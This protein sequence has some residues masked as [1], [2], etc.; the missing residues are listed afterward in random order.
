M[1][2]STIHLMTQLRDGLG[3]IVLPEVTSGTARA[4]VDL[5]TRVLNNLLAGQTVRSSLEAEHR[6]A[7]A[8]ALD[9]ALRQL[10][11]MAALSVSPVPAVAS[12]VPFSPLET[13]LSR[14]MAAC[15]PEAPPDIR[16]AALACLRSVVEAERRFRE[17][18]DPEVA[19]GRESLFAGGRLKREPAPERVIEDRQPTPAR[20]EA[21][22]RRQS[23]EWSGAV[24]ERLGLLSG[25]FGKETI[26]VTVRRG[27]VS[28]DLVIRRDLP[29]SQ[30]DATVT[31][32]FAPLQA[33]FAAGMRVPE[34]L[35]LETDPEVFGTPF[36]LMRKVEGTS[37]ISGWRDDPHKVDACLRSWARQ[38][39]LLHRLELP[40]E[41]VAGRETRTTRDW[42][43]AQIGRFHAMFAARRVAPSPLLTAGYAWLRANVPDSGVSPR[44]VH[45][46]L[47]FHNMLTLDGE[48][49]AI[50]DWEYAHPGDPQEDLNYVR[51]CVE[52]IGSWERFLSYYEGFGGP[53]WRPQ[54]ARFWEVWRGVWI[55]TGCVGCLQA[56]ESGQYANPDAAIKLAVAGVNFGPRHVLY[57]VERILAEG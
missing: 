15:G 49:T 34:V 8:R 39:A 29:V 9:E 6:A 51:P 18:L 42:I 52:S 48:V 13:A 56:F 24:V 20:L 5:A 44:L 21:W 1:E 2:V 57:G 41:Q 12:P 3:S 30:N 23:P 54:D 55:G 36:L 37:D 53:R 19:L 32:E 47:G 16:S 10:S 26:L 31:D 38:M 7:E 27:G 50:L 35:W 46:D 28:E 40:R 45:A 25:G 11:G 33:A 22:L 4:F 43:L 14:L 17:G